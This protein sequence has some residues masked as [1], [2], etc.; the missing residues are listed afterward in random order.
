[1]DPLLNSLAGSNISKKYEN[2][3]YLFSQLVINTYFK[4]KTGN[5]Y[6]AYEFRDKIIK[7]IYENDSELIPLVEDLFSYNTLKINNRDPIFNA[8]IDTLNNY[9]NACLALV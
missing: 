9:Y 2:L 8:F 7:N 6:S 5:N 1:L 4:S 3:D